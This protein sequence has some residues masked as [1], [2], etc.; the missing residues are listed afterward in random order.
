[1]IEGIYGKSLVS[2]PIVFHVF[3][4]KSIGYKGLC[5]LDLSADDFR[6]LVLSPEI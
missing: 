1:M 2:T 5:S 3:V 6:A 4:L